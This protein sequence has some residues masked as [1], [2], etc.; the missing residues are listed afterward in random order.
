MDGGTGGLRLQNTPILPTWVEPRRLLSADKAVS[1]Q[2]CEVLLSPIRY[3]FRVGVEVAFL[4][5]QVAREKMP[6]ALVDVELAGTALC[7]E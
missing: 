7:S 4:V 5:I 6:H 3:G 1:P 2:E